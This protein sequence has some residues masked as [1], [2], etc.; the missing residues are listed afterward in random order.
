MSAAFSWQCGLT[1]YYAPTPRGA[2]GDKMGGLCDYYSPAPRSCPAG[3]AAAAPK[4]H[5]PVDGSLSGHDRRPKPAPRAEARRPDVKQ[6]ISPEVRARVEKPSPETQRVQREPSSHS[7]T[8][9]AQSAPV[10]SHCSLPTM[11]P[12]RFARKKKRKKAPKAAAERPA[13]PDYPF[14]ACGI[15][16]ETDPLTS[17]RY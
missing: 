6:Q 17:P 15:A 12:P 5:H 3:A 9:T 2:H 7:S 14:W 4:W 11:P 8:D 16:E 10:Q 13:K 1:G